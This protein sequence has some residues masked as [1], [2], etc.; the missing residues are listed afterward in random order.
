MRPLQDRLLL[1]RRPG[2]SAEEEHSL[3]G[4]VPPGP[5]QRLLRSLLRRV[6]PS[7]RRGPR[8][9]GGAQAPR[10]RGGALRHST[11]EEPARAQDAAALAGLADPRREVAGAPASLHQVP[12]D[13]LARAGPEQRVLALELRGEGQELVHASH[14]LRVERDFQGVNDHIQV[15]HGGLLGTRGLADAV[16][17]HF[18]PQARGEDHV[19]VEVHALP[20][21]RA[22]QVLPAPVARREE[23]QD[24]LY[25]AGREGLPEVELHKVPPH[26]TSGLRPQSEEA[27]LAKVPVGGDPAAGHGLAEFRPRVMLP[28]VPPVTCGAAVPPVVFGGSANV[29]D[30][31]AASQGYR[32]RDGVLVAEVDV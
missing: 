23:L 4:V 26:H 32:L 31:E 7:P 6:Q 20:E 13:G 21:D 29:A 11:V 25:D 27:L 24:F 16:P 30:L 22:L 1:Q 18:C 3:E 14:L 10:G 12:A 8:G 17:S 9:R 5:H 2:D 28:P 19:L 15:L